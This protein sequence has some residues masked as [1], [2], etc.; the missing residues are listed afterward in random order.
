MHTLGDLA[1]ALNRPAVW[2]RGMQ[3]RFELPVVEGAGYSAAYLAFLRTVIFLRALNVGEDTLRHLWEL[4]KKFLV[5]L[6]ADN[7]GS[8]TWF[9]DSCGVRTNRHRR[10]LLSNFDIGVDLAA[11]SLQLGLN[12]NATLPELFAG[13]EMG[14][15]ALRVLGGYAE[16]LARVREHIATEL[17]QTRAAA[18]WA[19]EF[20]AKHR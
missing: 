9:L 6:H 1:K 20:T 16:Q 10:L 4:E 11:H 3:G 5:L 7:R 18:K 17:P 15:D 12:F 8:P 14:E 2:V 19:G 13:A